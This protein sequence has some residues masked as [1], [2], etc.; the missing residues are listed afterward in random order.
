PS[1]VEAFCSEVLG[2]QVEVERV[3]S[4]GRWNVA[5]R[6]GRR[7]SVSL[8]SEWGTGR[9]DA[10]TLLDAG[11]NQ[12]LHTVWDEG[13]D[14]RRVRND[15][16]TI[17]ARDKQDALASRFSA[18]VWEDPTRAERLAQRYNEL[19]SSV[20]VPV[21][22][23]SHLSLPGL[24]ENFTPHP[25]QRDAVARILTDGRA[26][27]AHAV[28]AG[29][30]ATM[31]MAAME[32]RRLGL[33]AKPAVVVPNHMLDQFSREW[34]QLYPTAKLLI[35]DRD[36]LSKERRKEFV[37]RC[38]TGDWDAVIFTQAGFGRVPLSARLRSAYMGQEL[39]TSREALAQSK[40]GKGLSVKRLE[41]RIAQLEETYQRLLAAETK[42][43]GV[44]WEESGIDYVFC[45]FTA[46]RQGVRLARSLALEAVWDTPLR[47]LCT[48]HLRRDH[49]HVGT[50][51]RPSGAAREPSRRAALVHRARH[52][53]G[54]RP[55]PC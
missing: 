43:D 20:V 14:G 4:L 38:A 29:K 27:L 18:W 48:P 6:A 19:F 31:V 28:G 44:R 15:A 21:H 8:S 51:R 47:G 45:D 37:A 1:D 26:L 39:A 34:L 23:G 17:A 25:H 50:N 54:L 13:A 2:A 12:R 22:D 10:V 3:A 49:G 9:A 32:L 55:R 46:H 42:D 40:G 33:V 53:Q 16:E 30:T 5:L 7:A 41:R 11:L 35:A 36:R 52:G 24:A